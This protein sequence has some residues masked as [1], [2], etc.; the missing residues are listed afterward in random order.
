MLR[1]I[2]VILALVISS[3]SRPTDLMVTVEI[4]DEHCNL[5]DEIRLHDD[6]IHTLARNIRSD[7]IVVRKTEP[8]HTPYIRTW[9][10]SN[11]IRTKN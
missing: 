1:L 7:R 10:T 4:W 5:V 11:P 8:N 2:T 3:S 6:D 9:Y